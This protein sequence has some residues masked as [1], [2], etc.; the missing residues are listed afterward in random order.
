MIYGLPD[1]SKPFVGDLYKW[2]GTYDNG[3]KSKILSAAL[4]KALQELTD[5]DA[6]NIDDMTDRLQTIT[7]KGFGALS[8]LELLAKL[9]MF[10][11]LAESE[12][13]DV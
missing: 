5:D 10:L 6:H 1:R 9:G 7:T 11:N 8:A 13:Y 2:D 4:A 3:E 12:G